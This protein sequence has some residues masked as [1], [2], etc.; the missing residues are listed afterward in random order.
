MAALVIFVS[1]Y[2][3]KDFLGPARKTSAS[4]RQPLGD[5]DADANASPEKPQATCDPFR[6]SLN[7]Q[8]IKSDEEM[9]HRPWWRDPKKMLSATSTR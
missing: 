8:N 5:T 6:V 4:W 1:E 9:K 3:E 7:F 2:L